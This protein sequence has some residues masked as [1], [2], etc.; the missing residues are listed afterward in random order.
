MSRTLTEKEQ[1]KLAEIGKKIRFSLD[2]D[3][4]DTGLPCQTDRLESVRLMIE[5]LEIHNLDVTN[6]SEEKK[7]E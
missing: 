7:N 4:N 1:E 3:I 5:Y 2:C 6:V